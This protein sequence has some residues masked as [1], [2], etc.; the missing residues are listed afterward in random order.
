MSS[1]HI[2]GFVLLVAGVFIFTT[3]LNASR[4]VVDQVSNTVLGRF[5]D[6]TSLYMIG[7]IVSAVCGLLLILFA[8]RGKRI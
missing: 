6:T 3:G 5:T 4:S 7:G 2:V 8:P 1:K